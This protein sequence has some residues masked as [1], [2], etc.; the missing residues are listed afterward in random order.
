MLTK[1]QFVKLTFFFARCTLGKLKPSC[2]EV[3]A[4]TFAGSTNVTWRLC[5]PNFNVLWGFCTAKTF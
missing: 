4:E 5:A 2:T 1:N 3:Q